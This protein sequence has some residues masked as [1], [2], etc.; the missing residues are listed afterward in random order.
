MG[1]KE[2]GFYTEDSEALAQVAQR[3]GGQALGNLI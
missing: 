1:H 2:E 3:G